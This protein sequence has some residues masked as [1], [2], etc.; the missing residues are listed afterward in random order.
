MKKKSLRA[1]L[2]FHLVLCVRRLRSPEEK[3]MR[4]GKKKEGK[5]GILVTADL[6]LGIRVG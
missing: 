3:W 1:G 6:I 2:L 5:K 4:E